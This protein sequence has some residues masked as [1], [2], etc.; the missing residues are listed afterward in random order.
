MGKKGKSQHYIPRFYL[1]EFSVDKTQVY[2]YDKL[3]KMPIKL[4]GIASVSCENDFYNI[5]TAVK[6]DYS[7]DDSLTSFEAKVAIDFHKSLTLLEQGQSPNDYME[8]LGILVVITHLRTKKMRIWAKKFH[9]KIMDWQ[10]NQPELID[11]ITKELKSVAP[12]ATSDQIQIAID[13]LNENLRNEKESV[14]QG[15]MLLSNRN[16]LISQYYKYVLCREWILFEYDGSDINYGFCTS[17]SPVVWISNKLNTNKEPLG[18]G[19]P[20]TD[21]IFPIS[22]KYCL[23]LLGN[24]LRDTSSWS[25]EIKIVTVDKDTVDQINLLQFQ[26]SLRFIFPCS[27]NSFFIRCINRKLAY[28]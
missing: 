27:S 16:K 5:G 25:R 17:D 15:N 19:T 20:H 14:L 4:V 28:I 6:K 26:K 13:K 22:P 12:E 3:V 24:N 18:M 21:V 10:F 2:M 7:L 11:D 23:L 9:R 8:S 1:R